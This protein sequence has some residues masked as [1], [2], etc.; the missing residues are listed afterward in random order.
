MDVDMCRGDS[1]DICH[2]AVMLSLLKD[3][4]IFQQYMYMYYVYI[5]MYAYIILD[6]I[7]MT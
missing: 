5:Y 4:N 2:G 3:L 6:Y 1:G 7:D